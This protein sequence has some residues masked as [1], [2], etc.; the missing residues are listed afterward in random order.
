M[1]EALGQALLYLRTDDQGLDAGINNARGKSEGLGRTFDQTSGKADGLGKAMDRTGASAKRLGAEQ[2]K[3]TAVSGAQRAG[4]QQLSMQLNDV[5]TMY[6]LGAR[7]MQ[8]FASQGGQVMQAVQLMTG[9]TSRLAAF[10]GGPWGLACSTAAIVLVPLIGNLLSTDDAATKAKDSTLDFTRVLDFRKMSVIEFKDAIDKLNESTKSLM[11]T[12]AIA[13]DNQA[14]N[15]QKAVAEAQHRLSMIDRAIAMGGDVGA[16]AAGARPAALADL[17]KARRSLDETRAEL[18]SRAIEESIDRSKGERAEI[19]R[20]LA[21]LKELNAESRAIDR[22]NPTARAFA[23]RQKGDSYISEEEYQQRTRGLQQKLYDSSNQRASSPSSSR[24][25]SVGDM[26]ALLKQLFPGATVTSTTS[27][28][29]T[30]GSDHYAGRAIDFVPKGGMGQYSTAEVEQMLE[31]AGVTIRRNAKGT[32]Q[33]FGPGRSANKSGDHDDHFHFAWSGSASPE[34]AQRRAERAA[35]QKR[36]E[37]EKEARRVERY[38]RDLAGLQDAALGLQTKL[39]DTADERY[40]LEREGLEK[41]IAEQKRRIEDNTEYSDAQKANLLLELEK[42]AEL[43]RELLERRRREE[44]A[45]QELQTAQA[46][47]ANET[48]LLQKQLQLTDARKERRAIE[49]QLLEIAYERRREALSAVKQDDDGYRAAQIELAGLD[50]QKALDRKRLDRDYASP[51]E[52]YRSELAGFGRNINDELESV[53]VSGLDRLN[54]GLADVIANARSLGD[55]FK[56][57]ADQIIAEL[58]RIAIRQMII[59]PLLNLIGGAFGGGGGG[60]GDVISNVVGGVKGGAK[61]AGFFAKG[62]LIPTGSFGI[63]GED[64]PEPIFATAGGVGVLPNS[65]L[66]SL[67]DGWAGPGG[68]NVSI[69]IPI[70]ATGADPAALGRVQASVDRLRAELPGQIVKTMQDAGDRRIVSTAKWR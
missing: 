42:K 43:E 56:Q 20:Q 23:I 26:V 4:M 29:H 17:E 5:A 49:L 40:R 28:R 18:Q 51:I 2:A 24:E 53:A 33:I 39:A 50:Q 44:L 46:L 35:E 19:E 3:V 59:A 41:T 30:K 9:G 36:R 58:M 64:G 15:A 66:R 55:A 54:D 63:V 10:L 57:V 12:Q 37:E 6:S 68:A 13:L 38:N 8:I 70:D 67:S 21:R 7:P 69:A 11:N 48:E 45:R 1:A 65:A 16:V 52:R 34:E 22:M 62:G 14:L 47:R 31:A 25:A 61:N 27:G 60:A 32:K